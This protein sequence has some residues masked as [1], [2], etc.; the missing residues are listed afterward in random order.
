[1][2][3]KTG[4]CTFIKNIPV[5]MKI[6]LL[7]FNINGG[8]QFVRSAGLYAKIINKL[9]NFII[10]RLRSGETRRFFPSCL[11]TI[12]PVSNFYFRYKNF[13]KAGYFRLKG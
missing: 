9:A 5:G 6:S 4:N 3:L 11:A 12:S 1:M 8:A 13:R 7:E 10:V 2:P